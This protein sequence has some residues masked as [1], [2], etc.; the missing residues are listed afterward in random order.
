MYLKVLILVLALIL[1][2]ESLQVFNVLLFYP[3]LEILQLN[4]LRLV[5]MDVL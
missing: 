2:L 5:V 4:N 1:A 3:Q